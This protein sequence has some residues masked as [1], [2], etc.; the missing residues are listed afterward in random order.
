M[1]IQDI[2]E[3]LQHDCM[4]KVTMR[5]ETQA[6]IHS[7]HGKLDTAIILSHVA[8]N[9]CL[10]EYKGEI[11]SAVWNPFSGYYYID[12]IYGKMTRNTTDK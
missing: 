7:L 5:K 9:H 8:N 11:C 4:P 3:A 1:A 12:D 6:V 10:A 2:D